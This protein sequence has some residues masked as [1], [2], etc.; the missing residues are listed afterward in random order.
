MQR[1]RRLMMPKRSFWRSRGPV[2]ASSPA[3]PV[4]RSLPKWRRFMPQAAT[5]KGTPT[6]QTRNRHRIKRTLEMKTKK[7]DAVVDP[8]EGE[9][10][11]GGG[12]CWRSRPT[13]GRTLPVLCLPPRPGFIPRLR[14]NGRHRRVGI[15][16][17]R[18]SPRYLLLEG[19]PCARRFYTSSVLH[20]PRYAQ[21][22]PSLLDHAPR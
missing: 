10:A 5:R 6:T 15:R 13:T 16:Q 21:W 4:R 1:S 18:S 2:Q 9:L 14:R 19:L 12:T 22:L 8:S 7:M 3:P 11:V 20:M 17:G